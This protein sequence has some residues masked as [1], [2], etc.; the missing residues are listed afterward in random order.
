MF[1]L[2]DSFT[3]YDKNR[4]PYTFRVERYTEKDNLHAGVTEEGFS[5]K[6]VGNRHILNTPAFHTGAFF[7]ECKVTFPQE[8][9]PEFLIYFQYDERTR[10][11]LGIR[12]RYLTGGGLEL[13]LASVEGSRIETEAVQDFPDYRLKEGAFMPV[14]LEVG[15]DR[16][17]CCVDG[18]EAVFPCDCLRGRLAL[19]RRNFIG[20]LIIR[21]IAFETNEEFRSHMVIPRTKV[22][23]P[24]TNGGDIPYTVFW[25]MEEVEKE[26]YL[27]CTLDGGTKSRVVNRQDRRGQYVAEVD[28]M[29]TPYIGMRNFGKDYICNIAEGSNCFVDPNI[30]WEC[31]KLFFGDVSL[32]LQVCYRMDVHAIDNQA[33]IIFGYGNLRC[34]GYQCQSGGR[35]F[36][37]RGDG[38]LVYEGAPL[39]GRDSFVLRSPCDKLAVSMIPEDCHRR[40]DVVHHFQNNHYFDVSEDVCFTMEF[41]TCKTLDYFEVYAKVTDVFERKIL[42]QCRPETYGSPWRY[43]YSRL[44][45]QVAFCPMPVGVY[46]VIFEIIYGD[47]VYQRCVHAFEVFDQ[48][49][50]MNP[51]LASGLPFLFSMPNEQKWLERNSFDPWNPVDSCDVEHYITCVTDTP[52][53]AERRRTWEVVRLFKRE[54][55]AWLG[56]RTCNDYRSERH[57]DVLRHAD[58]LFYGMESGVDDWLGAISIFPFRADH[59]QESRMGNPFQKGLLAEFFEQNPDASQVT[60]YEPE[61]GEMSREAFE[62]FMEHYREPWM[63]LVNSRVLELF[64][65][66]NRE[67]CRQNPGVR[68]SMYGPLSQYCA[69]TLSGHTLP[70]WG[71]PCDERLSDIIY[72]G[73][74]IFEDYPYSCAYQT[75]RGPFFV[76]NVLLDV[77]GL[78]IY[79]EQYRGSEGGCIDGAVKFAHAPM[80]GYKLEA[81]QNSTHAFEYVYNTPRLTKN[82]FRYWDTY[83]FHRH[84]YTSEFMDRLVLD[85]GHVIKSRPARPMRSLAFL[86]EYSESDTMFDAVSCWEGKR[87]YTISNYSEMGSALIHECSREAGVPNGFALKSDALELLDSGNCDLLVLPSMKDVSMEHKAQIRRLYEKGVNLIAVSDVDGLEDL[88]G[89]KE[90]RQELEIHEVH[91]N[92]RSEA[93]YGC[94]A[95]FRYVP[96]GAETIMT[97]D[98]GAPGILQTGRTMLINT[99]VVSL[100]SR[101]IEPI[102]FVN[103]SLVV[104]RLIRQ[105]LQDEI[106]RLSRPLALGKGVGITLYETED[107]RVEV[108]A[109]DYAPYDNQERTQREASVRLYIGDVADVES[110]KPLFVGRK[111]GIV[112]EIRF[113]VKPHESVFLELSSNLC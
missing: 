43:G 85:W 104:G 78:V 32:P 93:V 63:N 88:F 1:Q 7:M 13:A 39:D 74:A 36:R 40:E 92:G 21:Q 15:E 14:R 23:I 76:M 37:F 54:W 110:E 25:Q 87:K 80:G 48:A 69:P 70:A 71:L 8:Y 82:G 81:Y 27:H 108:L 111:E 4:Q 89:V 107:G 46:K 97:V 77:P 19:E 52:I 67:L 79:P 65:Q 41:C 66:Q 106:R 57:Q 20:E 61:K 53:E 2:K 28:W 98:G 3:A 44:M 38:G 42:A 31:Q 12:V 26:F 16:A 59:W 45:A 86:A 9:A 35:E 72:T 96:D 11:G 56:P 55:F 73:F 100:G 24:L 105:A 113:S 90:E 34:S 33:E 109:I 30:F 47:K 18:R 101:A 29:D 51:A 112:Q 99:D 49:S 22:E 91:Y 84:D 50:N 103:A 58:Y 83:G 95:R 10:R 64:E 6:S 75:Y 17:V 94:H 62:C 68:R 5:L 60:G 102:D